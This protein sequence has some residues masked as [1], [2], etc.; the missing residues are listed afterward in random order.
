MYSNS[1]EHSST[2]GID[3]III[4]GHHWSEED[5]GNRSLCVQFKN[6]GVSEFAVPHKYFAFCMQHIVKE[7]EQSIVDYGRIFLLNPM[8][9][10]FQEYRFPSQARQIGF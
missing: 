2:R 7:L 1:T 10:V 5:H 6:K 8:T 4:N 3:G 9:T